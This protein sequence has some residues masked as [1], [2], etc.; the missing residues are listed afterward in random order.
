[1]S[2]LC[3]VS[4]CSGSPN[5]LQ[6]KGSKRM[7]ERKTRP[8]YAFPK[9]LY[10]SYPSIYKLQYLIYLGRYTTCCHNSVSSSWQRLPIYIYFIIVLFFFFQRVYTIYALR[11]SG[12]TPTFPNNTSTKTT[13]RTT[14]NFSQTAE[15]TPVY[16]SLLSSSTSILLSRSSS[17]S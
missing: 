8:P 12:R 9:F 13:A 2:A 17:R 5:L 15:N 11:P 3:H 16:T 10:Y 4:P 6:V 7:L 14:A 1:M